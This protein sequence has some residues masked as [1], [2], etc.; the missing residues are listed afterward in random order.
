VRKLSLFSVAVLLAVLTFHA[1]APLRAAD[2][3][4]EFTK[5][6]QTLGNRDWRT[7]EKA[8]KDLIERGTPA[9]PAV[10][11]GLLS[12]DAEIRHRCESIYANLEHRETWR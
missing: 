11:R 8:Q 9:M 10:R 1:P 12:E 7:R 3:E 6:V 5:L 2:P 4:D